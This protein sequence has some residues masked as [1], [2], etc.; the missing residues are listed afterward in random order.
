MLMRDDH[1]IDVIPLEDLIDP[2]GELEP[3]LV[4]HRLATDI[5]HLFTR[6]FGDV[7]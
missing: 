6:K 5:G 1:A 2:G 3:N 4:I 7:L